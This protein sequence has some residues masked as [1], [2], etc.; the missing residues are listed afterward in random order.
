MVFVK[1]LGNDKYS[2]WVDLMSVFISLYGVR[3]ASLLP[4]Y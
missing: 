4:D 3:T 1:P 2:S